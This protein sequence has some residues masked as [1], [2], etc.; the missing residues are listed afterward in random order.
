MTLAGGGPWTD[1]SGVLSLVEGGHSIR[2]DMRERTD[3]YSSDDHL[4][5]RLVIDDIERYPP[6]DPAASVM[7]A[8]DETAVT[9]TYSRSGSRQS[10]PLTY[11][12]IQRTSSP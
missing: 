11:S 6:Y 2:S 1:A 7:N 9:V 4:G 8:M 12:C 3:Q 10:T 5:F